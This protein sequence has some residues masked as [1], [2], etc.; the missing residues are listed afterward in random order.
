MM[1]PTVES[2]VEEA[3]VLAFVRGLR[4]ASVDYRGVAA[5]DLLALFHARKESLAPAWRGTSAA[6]RKL[7]VEQVVSALHQRAEGLDHEMIDQAAE[8]ALRGESR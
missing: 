7:V 6:V 8:F 2:L 3:M 4:A 5:A 1:P